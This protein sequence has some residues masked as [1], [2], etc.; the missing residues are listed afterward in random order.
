MFLL[1]YLVKLYDKSIII[2]LTSDLT[3]IGSKIRK[4]WLILWIVYTCNV[5]GEEE[6]EK[7][8]RNKCTL[9][10]WSRSPEMSEVDY[11]STFEAIYLI[12]N[13]LIVG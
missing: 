4:I 6:V 1:Y 7:L 9:H 3:N 13:P 5:K 12:V 8:C 10:R 11:S 2:L